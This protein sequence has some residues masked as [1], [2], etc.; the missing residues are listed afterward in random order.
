MKIATKALVR[1]LAAAAK[2]HIASGA[3]SAPLYQPY[4]GLYTAI[5]P[6]P[7]PDSVFANLTEP[8]Y[9]GYAR[10]QITAWGGP[11]DEGATG[12]QIL[13]P[14]QTW[15]PS[16]SAV[17]DTIQGVFWCD[18]ASGAATL[19]GL[20]PLASPVPL[21][22]PADALLTV[23]RFAQLFAQDYGDLVVVP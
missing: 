11:F 16:D 13:G 5:S 20:D 18:A 12:S 17:S 21:S 10:Q 4:I 3:Y 14:L 6:N 23:C 19:L 7:S 22:G 15:N 1:L 2:A 8:T 9:T